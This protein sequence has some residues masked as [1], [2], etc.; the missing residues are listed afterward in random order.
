MDIREY[1]SEV[2][3]TDYYGAPRDGGRR[4]HTGTDFSHST[5][6]NTV[7]VPIVE[8]GNVVSR[9][10]DADW[11]GYGNYVEVSGDIGVW[12][13]AHLNTAQYNNLDAWLNQ[14][15]IVGL[16][17]NTGNTYGS[18]V[19]VELFIGGTR[20]D[21]W[22]YIRAIMNEYQPT[23]TED[24]EEEEDMQTTRAGFYTI[25]QAGAQL[26][27]VIDTTSGYADLFES[28]LGEYNSNVARSYGLTSN[29]EKVSNDHFFA[30]LKAA[31][32]V[33]GGFVDA[34][35]AGRLALTKF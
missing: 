1:Y 14:G 4:I 9:I 3:M 6:P 13:Y 7:P 27:A 25:D 32:E 2:Y 26:N 21:P 20:V 17:S 24:E 22:P 18:C 33:R 16:E 28:D 30:Q 31:A 34:K 11:H 23:E 12:R 5:V 10:S 19:H 15:D 35:I 8:P 29:F